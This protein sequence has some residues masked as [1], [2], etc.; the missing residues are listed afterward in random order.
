MEK[1][2][3]KA[4]A[5]AKIRHAYMAGEYELTITYPAFS[6]GFDLGYAAAQPQWKRIED[7]L[8][9]KTGAYPVVVPGIGGEPMTIVDAFHVSDKS[10]THFRGHIAWYPIPDYTSPEGEDGRSN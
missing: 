1:E 9:E 4:E 3:A 6:D 8:P 5:W 10:W 2:K 7:G